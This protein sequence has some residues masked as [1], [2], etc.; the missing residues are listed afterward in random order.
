L[1]ILIRGNA[2]SGD[3][4]LPGDDKSTRPN[5]ITGYYVNSS[6]W[7]LILPE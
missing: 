1:R 2:Q 5:N 6:D 4:I 7:R 3:R